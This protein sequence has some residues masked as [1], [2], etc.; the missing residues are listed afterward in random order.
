MSD[1]IGFLHLRLRSDRM[2]AAALHVELRSGMDAR[3]AAFGAQIWSSFQGLFGLHSRELILVLAY[4][5]QRAAF[6]DDI[7]SWLPTG[8]SIVERYSWVPTT[9]PGSAAPLTG[10]GLYVLRFFDIRQRDADEIAAISRAAWET[11][12]VSER[13]ASKPLALFKEQVKANASVEVQGR[14]LLI[15]WYDGFAS[16]Q[17]SRQPA[18]AA[19][20]HFKRR[21][22]LTSGTIAYACKL[23]T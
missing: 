15:T 20:D 4:P 12:E 1:S 9:R 17:T 5:L 16:W 21:A 10:E 14:M 6:V 13:Y 3:L 22:A 7:Q 8:V 19:V 23:L 18:P 2:D 11:F